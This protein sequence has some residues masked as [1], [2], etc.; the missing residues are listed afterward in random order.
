MRS[1][2]EGTERRSRGREER[3]L[4]REERRNKLGW[5]NL[6]KSSISFL[7]CNPVTEKVYE[8]ESTDA[9]D[10]EEVIEAKQDPLPSPL[11]TKGTSPDSKPKKQM[12]LKPVKQA[13]LMSF[14]KKN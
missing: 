12:D 5:Y 1:R 13:S 4:E 2:G 14:F 9:S 10:E 11:T 7:F 8:S 6:F 3:N